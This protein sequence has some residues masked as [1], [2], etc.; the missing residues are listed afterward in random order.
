[1]KLFKPT[2]NKLLFSLLFTII[3]YIYVY[4]HMLGGQLISST[5]LLLP[6][7]NICPNTGQFGGLCNVTVSTPS[8]EVIFINIAF[9]ILSFIATYFWICILTAL[10]YRQQY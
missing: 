4:H 3:L 5:T 9:I 8:L 10:I 2:L 6:P 7:T 1:M